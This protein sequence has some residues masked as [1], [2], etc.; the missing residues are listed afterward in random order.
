[1]FQVVGVH[2]IE[3][4]QAAMQAECN[5]LLM[6]AVTVSTHSKMHFLFETL[7]AVADS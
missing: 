2:C 5:H 1:M 4:L 7:H 6:P 3:E